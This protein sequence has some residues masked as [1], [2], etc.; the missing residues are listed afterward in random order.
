V[1]HYI[2]DSDHRVKKA[3]KLEWVMFFGKLDRY[4]ARTDFECGVFV[5]TVFLGLDH[6]G[7]SK[8]PP[9]VF[10]T[11]TFEMTMDGD[12]EQW[13]YSSWDDAMAGHAATVARV[14]KQLAKAGLST[15]E[16][17]SHKMET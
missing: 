4:L 11:M 3:T 16:Q 12:E 17:T 14:K 7:L 6:R 8:G 15:T 13:R 2:L 9:L 5:S 1:D 10:E